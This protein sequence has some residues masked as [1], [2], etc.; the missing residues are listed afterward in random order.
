MADLLVDREQ[1]R[2]LAR[3][4]HFAG[5]DGAGEAEQHGCGELVV[6]KA[7]LDVAALGDRGARI[8]C[9]DVAR[10]HAQR[11][12]LVLRG[13]VL[14]E[15]D[16]H[17]L[18]DLLYLLVRD[19]GGGLGVEDHAR[20][21]SAI[22]RVDGAVL[23]VGR[24]PLV[25]AERR[26]AQAPVVLDGA[27]HGA[28]GVDVAGKHE[29]LALPAQLDEDVALV[30]D[31]GRIAE[32]REGLNQIVRG[33]LGVAGGAGDGRE[34]RETLGDVAEIRIQVLLRS[35]CVRARSIIE[36]KAPRARVGSGRS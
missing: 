22:A 1:Q 17:V 25:A 4:R 35:L 10:L 28:Q 14:V 34:L 20:V 16:F 29:R 26:G 13:D 27:D 31:L 18:L 21:G 24:A 9:D 11:E 33:V 19:M 32:A 30:G 3:E 15:Q 36:Q 2:H 12:R 5:G 23:A 6:Q 7:A 8:H